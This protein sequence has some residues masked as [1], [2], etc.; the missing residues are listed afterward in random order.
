MTMDQ[1][2]RKF[3]DCAARAAT[4]LDPSRAETIADAVMRLESAAN[5]GTLMQFA[6]LNRAL[7]WHA[8][9]LQAFDVE[10]PVFGA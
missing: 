5:I 2:R 1:L 9:T 7:S 4:P 3:I 10:D 6:D 8:G